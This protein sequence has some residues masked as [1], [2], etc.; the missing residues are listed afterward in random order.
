MSA[1]SAIDGGARFADAARALLATP[2]LDRTH[3]HWGDVVASRDELRSFF[4]GACG[5]NVHVD[6]RGGFARLY[7][8]RRPDRTR[9]LLRSNGTP[10]RKEGYALLMLC[11]AEL[12]TRP[13]TTLGDLAANLEAAALADGSLTAFDQTRRRDRHHFV[14]AVRW[15]EDNLLIRVTAGNLQGYADG[16]GDAVIAADPARFAQL[17]ASTTPPSRIEARST[18]EW[19]AALSEEPRYGAVAGGAGDDRK[20]RDHARHQLGRMLLDDPVLHTAQLDG[21]VERYLSSST[22]RMV[23]LKAARRAG[24]V[25]E[26]AADCLVA[27]DPSASASD[28]TFGRAADTVTQVAVVLLSQLC[29]HRTPHT[30]PFEQ[31]EATVSALLADDEQWAMAYQTS[32]GARALTSEAV[33]AL[34]AFGLVRVRRSGDGQ[35]VVALPAA[36]RFLP[37][38]TD[39]RGHITADGDLG[40]VSEGGHDERKAAT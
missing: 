34:E 19:V 26:E 36:S 35:A 23:L 39:R 17:L 16:D 37:V 21:H 28:R 8:R 9:P 10:M 13:T 33:A 20:V 1:P 2:L 22:G 29:P 7:K 5:W 30:A 18:E 38:V 40:D 25:V 24:F 12:I 11:A 27:V 32:A 6:A 15:L 3:P 14:D 31:L 4:E